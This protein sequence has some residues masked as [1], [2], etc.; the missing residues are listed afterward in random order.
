MLSLNFSCMPECSE[1]LQC[2]CANKENEQV[3]LMKWTVSAYWPCYLTAQTF[4]TPCMCLVAAGADM[5]FSETSEW[6]V[7]PEKQTHFQ[8]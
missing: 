3:Y 2:D 5:S 4:F 7:R 1:L 6:L 8:M